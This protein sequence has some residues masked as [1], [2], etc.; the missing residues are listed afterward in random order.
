MAVH[1][2]TDA[3]MK[4]SEETASLRS[5]ILTEEV[6]WCGVPYPTPEK[7]NWCISSVIITSFDTEML[8]VMNLHRDVFQHYNARSHTSR[9]TVDFLANQ[10]VTVLLLPFKS[11][12]LNTIE[13]LWDDLDRRAHSRQPAPQ[14]AR[15]AAGSW[16]RMG[17]NSTRPY[18][19]NDRVYVETGPC[20]VTG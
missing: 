13:H 15:I 6:W 16:A 4:G 12:D 7:L 14:T 17:E 8:P 3:G 9:A 2:S 19:S 20:C 1:V 5:T 11:P 18:S 10:N